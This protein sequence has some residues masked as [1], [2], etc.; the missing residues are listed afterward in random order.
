MVSSSLATERV[1][2][3]AISKSVFV[4]PRDQDGGHC[5]LTAMAPRRYDTIAGGEVS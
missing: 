3:S 2:D 1:F 5:R 4:F